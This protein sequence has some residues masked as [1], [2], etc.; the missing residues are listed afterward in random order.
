MCL[1]Y[2]FACLFVKTAIPA[3]TAE[4]IETPFCGCVDWGPKEP[5]ISF[6]VDIGLLDDLNVL[7]FDLNVLPFHVCFV[8]FFNFL[9]V[10]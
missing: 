2:R 1:H 7:S 4:P 5:R 9:G 6:E 8:C 10:M 3:K